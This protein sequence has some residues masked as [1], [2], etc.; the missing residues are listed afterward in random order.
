MLIF[1]RNA[2]VVKNENEH[3]NII[4]R[5]WFLDQIPGKIIGGY[6]SAYKPVQAG[7]EH[8]G[9]RNPNGGP[10]QRFFDRNFMRIAAKN[11]QIND[12]HNNDKN[13]K[14]DPEIQAVFH[15]AWFCL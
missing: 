15:C 3:E 6:I 14:T 5:E 2:E 9:K 8:A 1:G 4:H 12:D 11:H 13:A 10:H 7:P